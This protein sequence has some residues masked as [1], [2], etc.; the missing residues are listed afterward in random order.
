MSCSD[1]R[2]FSLHIDVDIDSYPYTQSYETTLSEEEGRVFRV[3][4]AFNTLADFVVSAVEA[5]LNRTAATT[6]I[7]KRVE[8]RPR[9]FVGRWVHALA[10]TGPHISA[11]NI[12][13]SR[14]YSFVYCY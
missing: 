4:R 2:P 11:V 3:H 5:T 6:S 9:A 10:P 14:V 8:S 12:R 7:V 13:Y 1:K